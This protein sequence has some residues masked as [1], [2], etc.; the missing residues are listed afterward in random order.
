[1]ITSKKQRV[2]GTGPRRRMLNAF[3]LIGT[4]PLDVME[5][6][7]NLTSVLPSS[8]IGGDNYQI[9]KHIDIESVFNASTDQYRQIL[10]QSYVTDQKS[11]FDYSVWEPGTDLIQSFLR[12]YFK[13]IYRLRISITQPNHTIPWHIDTDTSVVCRAQICIDIGNNQFNFKTKD[14]IETLTMTQGNMYFINTG[15][16]HQVINFDKTRL[17]AIFAFKFEDLLFP[18]LVLKTVS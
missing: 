11:E 6:L 12:K 2:N 15:W 14:G 10:L 17:V 9:A 5:D 1:M 7:K 16:S 4:V 18:D 13:K 3:S 8:T